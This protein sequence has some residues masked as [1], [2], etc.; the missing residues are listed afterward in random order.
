MVGLSFDCL[1]IYMLLLLL[2]LQGFIT[3]QLYIYFTLKFNEFFLLHFCLK[4]VY[5]CCFAWQEIAVA[6]VMMMLLLLT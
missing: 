1:L 5:S 4:V 3:L 2:L 6:I